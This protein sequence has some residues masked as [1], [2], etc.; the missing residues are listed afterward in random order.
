M[1]D[2]PESDWKKFRLVHKAALDRHCQETLAKLKP[3]I[4]A[5]GKDMHERYMAIYEF[6]QQRDEEV[7]D[8]FN[9]FRRSTALIQLIAMCKRKLV[10]D[11]ELAEFSP[12]TRERV[13]SWLAQ[14]E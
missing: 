1:H 11:E 14:I 10:T 7:A 13:T 2:F 6:I 9:D 5:P 3:M 4:D 12:E 8:V